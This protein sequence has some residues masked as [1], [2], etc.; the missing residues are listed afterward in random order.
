MTRGTV[1]KRLRDHEAELRKLG[2]EGL[3]LFGSVARGE[4]NE[5]SDIDVAVKLDPSRTPLGLAYFGF[6]DDIEQRL[7]NTLGR[8]VDVIHEP[9]KKVYLQ[10]E[11]D[12]DR[13]VAF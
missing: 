3:S 9:S 11:I 5:A 8:H 2:I 10:R 13:C 6:L 4:D 7:E 1:L 12:R